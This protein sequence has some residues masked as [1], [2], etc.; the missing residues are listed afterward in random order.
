EEAVELAAEKGADIQYSVY[1]ESPFFY[2]YEDGVTHE[3]WFEDARSAQA[4]MRL[5]E[6]YGLA[7][8]SIWTADRLW[9]PAL[10]VLESLFCVEKTL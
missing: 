5:V 3:V 1:A 6:E 8:L 7:G 2:Y 10:A 9:R 4:R